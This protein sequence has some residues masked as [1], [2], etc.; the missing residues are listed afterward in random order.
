MSDTYNIAVVG[1]TGAVGG[2]MLKLLEERNFP[3]DSLR[4]LAS[5]R[6]AGSTVTFRG[7][8][9]EVEELTTESFEGVQIALFSAGGDRSREFAPAAVA[10]GAVVIDNSSAFRME[11]SVPLVVPEVNPEDVKWHEGIIANPNCSTIQMVVA[12]K[13]IYDAVGIDRI[14]VTTFQSVSGTGNKAIAELFSQSEAVL[15]S[16]DVEVNVHP[17]RIAFN[18]LPQIENFHEDGYTNEEVKMANET[19]KIFGDPQIGVS[20]TCVRVPVYNAHSEAVNIQTTRHVSVEEVRRLLLSAPGVTL[21]DNPDA[22]E[23]PMPLLAEGLDDVFVGRIRVDES[24]ENSLNL[25]V[26]SDNLRKGA[27]TNAIQIAEL[28]ASGGLLD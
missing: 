26:V 27:A 7:E 1:A 2:V 4:A 28:L 8:E 20:A 9:I 19:R 16:G 24:A 23:Y 6:S 10:A 15:E 5:G 21:L 12:L 3:V 22:G 18:V 11:A 25:W 14:I 17:H 13:P